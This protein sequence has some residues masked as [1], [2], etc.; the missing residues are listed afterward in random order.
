MRVVVVVVVGGPVRDMLAYSNTVSFPTLNFLWGGIPPVSLSVTQTSIDFSS[1]I[2]LRGGI[3]I[4][5]STVVI[6]LLPL[7][8]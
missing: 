5:F 3:L 7:H 6:L 2:S 8:K 4:C 1:T